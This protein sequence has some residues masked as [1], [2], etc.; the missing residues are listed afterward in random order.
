MLTD[1]QLNII[2]D[3]KLFLSS[4]NKEK[5]FL[6]SAPAGTG[7]TFLAQYLYTNVYKKEFKQKYSGFAFTATTHK[8]AGVL[9]ANLRNTDADVSTIHSFLGL[10]VSNDYETGNT[11]ITPGKDVIPKSKFII[12]VDECSMINREL[13]NWINQLTF[14]CKIIFMGDDKQLPPVGDSLSPVFKLDLPVHTLTKIIRSN[15]HE[16]ITTICNQLRNTVETLEFKDLFISGNIH[17]CSLPEFQKYVDEHFKENY[18]E[19]KI[20]TYTNKKCIEY[21]QYISVLRGQE[22]FLTEGNYY[23][24]NNPIIYCNTPEEGYINHNYRN[25]SFKLYNNEELK[26]TKILGIKQDKQT[27]LEYFECKFSPYYTD[28][29]GKFNTFKVPSQVIKVPVDY[30]EFLETVSAVSSSKNWK[31]YFRLKETFADLRY[32]D[33]STVHKAQGSTLDKV[34]I[35]LTDLGSCRQRSV[36]SRLLYVALSRA[37]EEIYLVGALPL[38]YGRIVLNEE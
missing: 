25:N 5:Y 34:F 36:F 31:E 21:N 1:E 30:S 8:A 26:I 13:F 3:I 4:D 18:P 22:R 9:S 29:S 37:K 10:K 27:G 33:A 12:V 2:N 16:E 24:C 11:K 6:I 28:E 20:L 19:G 38:K 23:V 14:K 15:A 32:R 35:D 17:Y 7:K